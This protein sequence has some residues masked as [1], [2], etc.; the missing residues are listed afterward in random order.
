[1][2][3][4]NGTLPMLDCRSATPVSIDSCKVPAG[5]FFHADF[6]HTQW[7]LDISV[8]PINYVEVLA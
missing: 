7:K 5:T 2:R 1:M 4:F 3:T 8:L 6:I